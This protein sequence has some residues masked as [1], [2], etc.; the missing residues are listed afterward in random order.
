[1]A[2]GELQDIPFILCL[3]VLSVAHGRKVRWEPPAMFHAGQGL[4][5]AELGNGALVYGKGGVGVHRRSRVVPRKVYLAW[6]RLFSLG[7]S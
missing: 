1:M 7:V 2:T 4:C 3:E 6:R 5:A